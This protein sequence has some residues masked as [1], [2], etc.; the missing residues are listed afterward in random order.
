MH[1]IIVE[2][3]ASSI[4]AVLLLVILGGLY[5][6]NFIKDNIVKSLLFCV[7]YVIIT[8]WCTAFIPPIF[9][10]LIISVFS[11]LLISLISKK[12]IYG[13]AIVLVIFFMIISITEGILISIFM[14]VENVTFNEI[15]QD[16]RIFRMFSVLSKI[17]QIA[18]GLS[19]YKSKINLS[20]YNILS[21]EGQDLSIYLLEFD[22]IMLSVLT[23]NFRTFTKGNILLYN[24]LMCTILILFSIIGML[25]LKE[26]EKMM[27]ILDKYK[28]QEH[29]IKNMEDIISI[30]RK[31]KHDFANHISVIQ[32]LCK[33]NKDDSLEKIDNYVSKITNNIHK[34]YRFYESGND[35]IDGILTIKHNQAYQNGIEFDV[36]I[37]E[38]FKSIDIPDDELI[39]IVSNLLDNA[40]E[41]FDYENYN[42]NKQI[43][44][45]PFKDEDMFCLEVS[46][47]GKYIPEE[48]REKIFEKGFSTKK[49]NKNNHGF[50]LFIVKQLVTKNDGEII[51]E[52]S[53]E[54]TRFLVKFKMRREK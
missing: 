33:L 11:I 21:K 29:H 1:N 20:K 42:Q 31:E 9:R 2:I 28:I 54:E 22:I 38:S 37:E 52:S 10:T 34:T 17:F 25:E 51:V 27:T 35:Y 44:V 50:G 53:P 23:V 18:I 45:T 24:V 14:L 48:I 32:G 12:S 43:F 30:M 26:R 8:Y 36:E 16:E 40:L 7:A 46:D 6:Q 49:E 4:E 41:S 47:N 3:I 19:I 5:K 13:S 15:L 39:G